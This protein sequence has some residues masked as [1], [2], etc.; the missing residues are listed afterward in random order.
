[1]EDDVVVAFL[2]SITTRESKGIGLVSGARETTGWARKHAC[3]ILGSGVII[4]SW[5][6]ING[7]KR[8]G[9][10]TEDESFFFM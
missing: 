5:C 4:I 2:L 1:M 8:N 6:L 7:K 3:R 9:D 10:A